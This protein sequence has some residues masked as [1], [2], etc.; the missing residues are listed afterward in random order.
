MLK[1]QRIEELE[2]QISLLPQ[3][4]VVYK[5]IRGNRQPYLQWR[6]NG[7]LKSLYLKA[8][9]RERIIEQVAQRKKLTEELKA[10]Q[11][12]ASFESEAEDAAYRTHV[13]L[14]AELERLISYPSP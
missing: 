7:K 14:G 4:T 10:L 1:Q 13:M 8:G 9:D 3:G 2:K 12:L 11:A 6:E 5:N